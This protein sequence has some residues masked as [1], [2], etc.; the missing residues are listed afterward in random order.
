[1]PALVPTDHF[2]IV[3]WMG[4]VEDSA[5]S[6]HADPVEEMN[7]TFAGVAG[8]CHAGLTRSSCSRVKDQHPRGTQIANVRQFSILS[9][10]ELLAIAEACNIDEFDP[11]WVGASLVIEGIGDFSHVPPSSRL[12]ADSGATLV[13]DMENRPCV[14]PGR[15]IEKEE[16]GKGKAFKHA[17]NGLRGVTAWVEREGLLKLGDVLRLHIPDQPIW[18]HHP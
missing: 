17:A 9:V 16:P 13:V 3:R 12:Q 4:I 18:A 2:A 7:V 8:E 5:N 14:L 6:L 10:E 15:V 1:M 11:A